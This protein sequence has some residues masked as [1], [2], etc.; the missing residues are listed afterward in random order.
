MPYI[1]RNGLW[2]PQHVPPA[3]LDVE[4]DW[5]HPLAAGL[6]GCYVP[7]SARGLNDIAG[8]GP[9]LTAPAGSNQVGP[10]GSGL[11]TTATNS[12]AR[13]TLPAAY[14]LSTITLFWR[15]IPQAAY[16]GGYT[17][18]LFGSTAHSGDTA[19]SLSASI[20][21]LATNNTSSGTPV[22][23]WVQGDDGGGT[24][25]AAYA[26]T[27]VSPTLGAIQSAAVTF[28]NATPNV[29][30]DG[31]LKSSTTS[32][33][34]LSAPQYYSDSQ[35][36]LGGY[37]PVTTRESQTLNQMGAIWNRALTAAEIE[38]L[39]KEPFAMLREKQASRTYSLAQTML[40]PGT[41]TETAS[42][43]APSVTGIDVTVS[44]SSGG[45]TAT[46]QAPT[47]TNPLPVTITPGAGTETASAPFGDAG[48]LGGGS[49]GGLSLGGAGGS[50]APILTVGYP[51]ISESPGAGAETG[52]GAAPTVA[53]GDTVQPSADT[54][55]AAGTAPGIVIGDTL[56]PASGAE[57]GAGQAPSLAIGDI[58]T[59]A[60][61]NA[62][63]DGSAPSLA[64]GD[65]LTP[66]AGTDTATSSPPSVT[67]GTALAPPAGGEIATGTAPS[68]A[69]DG[70]IDGDA[71]SPAPEGSAA[72]T[73]TDPATAPATVPAPQAAGAETATNPASGASTAPAAQA[74]GSE[75][76]VTGA[77]GT[78]IAADPQTA[79]NAAA[80]DPASG[81]TLTAG[82]SASG[83][84]RAVSAVN[85][86]APIAA[87]GATYIANHAPLQ[88]S[89]VGEVI[90]VSF[91][92][93]LAAFAGGMMTWGTI[94]E[95]GAV[96]SG[97][98]L[99]L[100][101]ADGAT[102]LSGVQ[103]DIVT[104]WPDGSAKFAIL[105]AQVPSVPA[106]L[107]YNCFLTQSAP[108]AGATP[109]VA[110]NVAVNLT[111]HNSDGTTTPFSVSTAQLQAAL[112]TSDDIRLNGPLVT[113]RR[114]V[115]PVRN[116]LRLVFDVRNYSDGTI[117]TDCQFCNDLV[118]TTSGGTETYDATILLDGATW[119]STA[120]DPAANA[121]SGL[122]HD[123]YQTWHRITNNV[124]PDVCN[125]VQDTA[126]MARAG[127]WLHF[128]PY[129]ATAFLQQYQVTTN[130][131]LGDSYVT[132]YMPTTGGRQD[133]GPTTGWNAAWIVSQNYIFASAS[134]AAADVSGSVPWN[135]FQA[136]NG[137]VLNVIDNKNVWS[138]QT[139]PL[140]SGIPQQTANTAW[141]L[142]SEHAPDLE[143]PAAVMTGIRYHYDRLV[144]HA[145]WCIHADWPGNRDYIQ[146]NG[147]GNGT[148]Y[149]AV[150]WSFGTT[151]RWAA[152]H[153]RTVSNAAFISPDQS[154]YQQYFNFSLDQTFAYNE[155]CN[156]Q[157]PYML[158]QFCYF[159]G[160]EAND[161]NIGP[162]QLDYLNGALTMCVMRGV[163]RAVSIM[164]FGRQFYTTRFF[165]SGQGFWPCDAFPYTI[166]TNAASNGWTRIQPYTSWRDAEDYTIT[167]ENESNIGQ[168]NYPHSQGDYAPYALSS[169]KNIISI[170]GPDTAAPEVTA[171][172]W[173]LNNVM[174]HGSTGIDP[175]SLSQNPMTAAAVSPTP[176]N[177][178][179]TYVLP[180]WAVAPT[181][182]GGTELTTS[183]V[184]ATNASI[185]PV[186][187]PEFGQ[188]VPTPTIP[189]DLLAPPLAGTAFVGFGGGYADDGGSGV[190]YIPSAQAAAAGTIITTDYVD[191]TPQAPSPQ[192]SAQIAQTDSG[193]GGGIAGAPGAG[194]SGYYSDEGTGA[195]IAA[196]PA[197]SGGISSGDTLSGV[198]TPP[199]TKLSLFGYAT[200]A[201]KARLPVGLQGPEAE[202]YG[203]PAIAGD[204]AGG[205]LAGVP[206]PE[207]AAAV[208]QTDIAAAQTSVTRTSLGL[209]GYPATTR[210]ETGGI[211]GPAVAATGYGAAPTPETLGGEAVAPFAQATST[212]SQTDPAFGQ[213]IVDGPV[214]AGLQPGF[215][216][217][218]GVA[219]GP[220]TSG[221]G[222]TSVTGTTA[223]P[224]IIYGPPALVGTAPVGLYPIGVG[225]AIRSDISAGPSAPAP[226]AAAT[227]ADIFPNVAS[228]LSPSFV[229]P[230]SGTAPVGVLPVGLYPVGVGPAQIIPAHDGIEA[231][232][233]E[234]A[235]SAIFQH[236]LDGAG[237]STVA[238]PQ[239][240]GAA[241]DA[242]TLAG[243]TDIPAPEATG[244]ATAQQDA[245]GTATLYDP[246]AQAAA[247]QGQDAEGVAIAPSPGAQAGQTIYTGAEA[248]TAA[249]SPK[250]VAAAS[251]TNAASGTV[252]V[253][254]PDAQGFVGTHGVDTAIGDAVA[255]GPAAAATAVQAGDVAGDATVT[256]PQAA[257]AATQTDSG[258]ATAGIPAPGT[259][260]AASQA[261]TASGTTTIGAPQAEGYGGAAGTETAI[262]LATA[263]SP[264][265]AASG[266]QTGQADGAATVAA[267]EAAATAASSNT[268][269][270]DAVIA[271]PTASG[272]ASQT[273]VAAGAGQ[274]ANPEAFGRLFIPDDFAG[275][276]EAPAPGTEAEARASIAASGEPDLSGPI[277]VGE[278]HNLFVDAAGAATIA[279]PQTYAEMLQSVLA[280]GV[281]IPGTILVSAEAFPFLGYDITLDRS[282]MIAADITGGL[283]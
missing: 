44:S 127:A 94:F 255:P 36:C 211:V 34:S 223:A 222:V 126:S 210:H 12:M 115:I 234:A 93:P 152:W 135:Y 276:A 151:Y 54:A 117:W 171:M 268:A 50:N 122:V 67:A 272:A 200:A 139:G 160:A 166:A 196:G 78:G 237:V 32:L 216:Q 193:S 247:T 76:P 19:P 123:L 113:E 220:G 256:A 246:Q 73:Q 110:A 42:G 172:N 51:P 249:P 147:F 60:A 121:A 261:N 9:T 105:T 120:T 125:V 22:Y 150:I 141:A 180:S 129:I 29:Y 16:A 83:T 68:V 188:T 233:P 55:T 114:A 106:G 201:V 271:G 213:G 70:Y 27:A 231:G 124:T 101:Q 82:P 218:V 264:Q 111:L 134:I 161:L 273:N 92:A 260:A 197:A 229:L 250:A 283:V 138:S 154:W 148:P 45:A 159:N 23:A 187:P 198:N 140:P 63:A 176:L 61:G 174:G 84:A 184:Q 181:G 89:G 57:A 173:M 85:S 240:H 1:R 46:G 38:W 109:A 48:S 14:K 165:A 179:S 169:M 275:D 225:E 186:Q 203:F 238:A 192:A 69:T 13:A 17:S 87:D 191:I 6:I 56:T 227:I 58:L 254:G 248:D 52:S 98:G 31:A 116:A 112:N 277:L 79:A 241:F 244:T 282:G 206:V 7:G 232:A 243:D 219:G 118:G 133:I 269:S 62:A 149:Y 158:G 37:A 86:L 215:G 235:G 39:D 132:M 96:P 199:I 99:M 182:G 204:D 75:T 208:V 168:P 20:A 262:G 25:T 143:F 47:V 252:N 164:D 207:A 278:G 35:L 40:Q 28:S 209:F 71:T 142:S 242:Q 263:P 195:A 217:G 236:A 253:P 72:A 230:G 157:L 214:G 153:I 202:A 131:P 175:Y 66:G 130:P 137:R 74:S 189:S 21:I 30:V 2:L 65:T 10:Y 258:E 136:S 88:P 41:G 178:P 156:M 80:T 239:A 274:P 128:E 81:T 144:T 251:Q 205:V 266:L 91:Q 163:P 145:G 267:P 221:S 102:P 5:N 265:A 224:Q 270:G 183:G 53:V 279:A 185:V 49:V 26:E 259:T 24:L 146:Y 18:V 190:A 170:Y 212:S 77:T 228:T 280:H 108:P 90:G 43:A 257:G 177:L 119:Y 167:R 4:I 194:A 107:Q 103:A 226:Q 59:P 97:T 281:A 33:S 100:T 104:R 64:V 8:I 11:L 95:Q 245:S 15:G 3:S 155:A 162:W